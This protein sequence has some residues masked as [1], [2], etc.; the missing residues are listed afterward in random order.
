MVSRYRVVEICAGAGGQSLGL[1]LAGFEHD[2]SVE[3]TD[4]R[5][6]NTL[7]RRGF[8]SHACVRRWQARFL[9]FKTEKGTAPSVG[10]TRGPSGHRGNMD[11]SM[12][13]LRPGHTGRPCA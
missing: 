4:H 7:L 8:T 3:F 10:A 6:C 9:R 13:E 12:P 2:L 11:I 1:E 5:T